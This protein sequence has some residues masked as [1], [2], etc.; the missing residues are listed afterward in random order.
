MFTHT[1]LVATLPPKVDPTH[2]DA[3][4]G[5]P[6]FVGYTSNATLLPQVCISLFLQ[7]SDVLLN[8]LTT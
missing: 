3:V 8:C 7:I 2:I 5:F 4:V 6:H 1:N